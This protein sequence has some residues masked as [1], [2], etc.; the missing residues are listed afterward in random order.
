MLYRYI[1]LLYK[2]WLKVTVDLPVSE[3]EGDSC[4]ESHVSV[5]LVLKHIQVEQ[6]VRITT[7][8]TKIIF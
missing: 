7:P 3:D 8:R 2:D 5:D 1:F 6:S 4:V